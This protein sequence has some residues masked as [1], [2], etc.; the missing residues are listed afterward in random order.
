MQLG[1]WQDTVTTPL[2]RTGKLCATAYAISEQHRQEDSLNPTGNWDGKDKN[3]RFKI[4]GHL[5]SNYATDPESRRSVT[6]TV[7][8]LNDAPIAFS[9]VTQKH[10]TLSVTEAELAPVVTM[11]MVQDMTYVYRVITSMGLQVDLP[12]TAEMDT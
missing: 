10:V 8:Y 12:M 6:D 9:S 3:F 1:N 7:V 11:T 2:R 5:D 4:C